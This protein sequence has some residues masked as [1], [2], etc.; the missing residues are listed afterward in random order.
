[1]RIAHVSRALI[2]N[3]TERMEGPYKAVTDGTGVAHTQH[4]A[5]G[6]L[7]AEVA[8]A[9]VRIYRS[10]R[11]R[12]PTKAHAT[13]RADVIVVVLEDVTTPVERS[14]I[15]GG[16][17]NE[18][19]AVRR[20]LHAMMRAPLAQAIAELTGARVRTVLGDSD[21]DP[22]IAAEVFILDQHVDPHHGLPH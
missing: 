22:D 3:A 15:A 2:G 12:G 18:A 10:V 4:G 11:G 21:A 16:R 5:A 14:L 7:N 13:F 8:R 20:S 6:E 1:M 19:L 17:A 9:V